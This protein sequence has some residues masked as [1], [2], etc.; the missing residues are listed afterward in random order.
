[1]KNKIIIIFLLGCLC[2]LSFTQLTLVKQKDRDVHTI[3]LP[4]SLQEEINLETSTLSDVEIINYAIINCL[5]NNIVITYNEIC[6]Y[7]I[8]MKQNFPI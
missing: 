1:M 3:S 6:L 5:G 2:L 4:K 7:R 8:I